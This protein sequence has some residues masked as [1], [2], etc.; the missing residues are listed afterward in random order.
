MRLLTAI[1]AFCL[2]ASGADYCSLIVKVTD[3]H[4]NEPEVAVS[5]RERDGRFTRQDNAQGG[6]GFCNLGITPVEVTVGSPAC[7]QTIVRNV[8]VDWAEERKITILYDPSPCMVDRPPV[9]ACAFLFRFVDT[10]GEPLS[11]ARFEVEKPYEQ[12]WNG[13]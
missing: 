9:A 8:P 6:V 1:L 12:A 13:M 3:P 7:N 4:G 10:Q 5:V 11:G 2:S